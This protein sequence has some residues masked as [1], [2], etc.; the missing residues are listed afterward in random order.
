MALGGLY[1]LD[2]RPGGVSSERGR[3]V[4]GAGDGLKAVRV[5]EPDSRP[6]QAT[7]LVSPTA[8]QSVMVPVNSWAID[9]RQILHL[10]SR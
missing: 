7:G 4:G 8:D 3:S 1:R 10:R 2:H 5:P 9:R 6:M